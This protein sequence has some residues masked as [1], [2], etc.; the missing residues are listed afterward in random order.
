MRGQTLIPTLMCLL[1]AFQATS[2]HKQPSSAHVAFGH[3]SAAAPEHD[4]FE[5]QTFEVME[6]N[7]DTGKPH[8]RSVLEL[9]DVVSES[10][11][12]EVT[13]V[14]SGEALLD[15]FVRGV[16]HIEL[17]EHL[18]LTGLNISPSFRLGPVPTTVKSIRV[19][20]LCLLSHSHSCR[21]KGNGANRRED[22]QLP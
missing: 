1:C 7:R 15:A 11:A 21:R 6:A 17:R 20:L 18:D 14:T 9:E 2:A 8:K 19:C 5:S 10:E 22:N 4:V 12:A 13:V 16:R 3:S